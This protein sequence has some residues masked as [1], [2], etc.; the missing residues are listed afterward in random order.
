MM[1]LHCGLQRTVAQFST[2]CGRSGLEISNY[3]ASPSEGDGVIEVM[4][5]TEAGSTA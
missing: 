3:W 2:L 4:L 5:K 1:A